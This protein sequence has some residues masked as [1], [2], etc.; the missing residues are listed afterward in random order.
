MS[1]HFFAGVRGGVTAMPRCQDEASLIVPNLSF[2]KTS[3]SFANL[4]LGALRFRL[5]AVP[6]KPG[7]IRLTV[8]HY[9]LNKA[10]AKWRT[11]LP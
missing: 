8:L 2:C 7:Y 1:A 3:F 9:S 5:F 6:A 4:L 11:R 10:A